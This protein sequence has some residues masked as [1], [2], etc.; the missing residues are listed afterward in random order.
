MSNQV[1]IW[2]EPKLIIALDNLPDSEAK[3]V[4]NNVSRECSEFMNRIVF[5]VNDLLVDVWLRWVKK[6]VN[7][8]ESKNILQRAIVEADIVLNSLWVKWLKEKL[9]WEWFWIMLDPK[10]HDISNTDAN[11]IRKLFESGLWNKAEFVTMHASNWYEALKKAVDTRNELWI[12]TKILAVTALTTLDDSETNKIFDETSKHSVLKLAKEALR[13]GVDWIVCSAMEAQLLRD[14]FRDYDFEIVTPWVRFEDKKV[15]WDD[16]KRVMTPQ[17]SIE[18]WASHV[19]MWRP[20]LKSWDV[21]KSVERFF[22]E[23]KWVWY[24]SDEQ[25]HEFERLL[26]TWDWEELLRYIWAFYNRPEWGKYCRLAS[27]LLSNAYINIWATERNYLVVERAANEMA[28]EVKKQWIKADVIMWAQMWS[29]RMSLYLAEKLWIEESVYT[30]KWWENDKEMLL[31]R[32][33]IDLN[34]KKII[35]SEDIITKWSTLK[36]MIQL[37][38][39]GWWEVVAITCVWKR[40][41]NDNFEW[42][43]IISCYTPPKFELYYDENTPLD[44]RKDYPKLPEW[45]KISEKAKNEWPELVQSMRQ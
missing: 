14:V 38:N 34:W 20:I 25:R 4:I 15:E 33:D 16:Q 17:K 43:P 39:D 41:E 29:V 12:K 26:Y 8:W 3:K 13:A 30:E 24:C 21:K 45:S 11:Y 7:R 37:V 22:E 35:L 36:K 19:V 18:Q 40:Y 32:H 6:T 44:E 2:N 42:I 10:W 27:G 31:K 5:K 28:D 1:S 23:I 9:Y